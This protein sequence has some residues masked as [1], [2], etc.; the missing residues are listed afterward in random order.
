[1]HTITSIS[2][3]ATVGG[4]EANQLIRDLL[5]ILLCSPGGIPE[6]HF[7]ELVHLEQRAREGQDA[8]LL[9]DSASWLSLKYLLHLFVK[10][11][12]G[13]LLFAHEFVRQVLTL[14]Y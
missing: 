5:C 8:E 13:V 6:G 2:A 3:V 12:R 14:T 11:H 10:S 4:S 9:L 1:M 7:V